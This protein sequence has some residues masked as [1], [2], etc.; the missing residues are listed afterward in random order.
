MFTFVRNPFDRAISLWKYLKPKLTFTEFI[1]WL[2]DNDQ[3][4][5]FHDLAHIKSCSFYLNLYQNMFPNNYVGH[6]ENI[7]NDFRYVCEQIGLPSIE[8]PKIRQTKH[9]K[10]QEYYNP[11]SIKR[12]ERFYAQDLELFDYHF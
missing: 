7:N 3:S 8:V 2:E 5:S 6:V 1:D 12:I 4:K 11:K 10:Y 9:N